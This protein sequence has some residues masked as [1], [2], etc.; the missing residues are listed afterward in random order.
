MN[1][2][3]QKPYAHHITHISS[4]SSESTCVTLN[5]IGGASSRK[6]LCQ[7][8]YVHSSRQCHQGYMG[9]CCN[10]IHQLLLEQASLQVPT[11]PQPRPHYLQGLDPGTP[12]A[13]RRPSALICGCRW[14]CMHA[15]ECAEKPCPRPCLLQ[16]L[17][18]LPTGLC[19]TILFNMHT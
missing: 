14:E 17:P 6:A 8:N 10:M 9:R 5:N 16:C 3:V 2:H 15:A 7:Q 1:M 19:T 13:R 12:A 18:N 4:C 11:C